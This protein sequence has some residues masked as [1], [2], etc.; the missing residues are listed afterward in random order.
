MAPLAAFLQEI[1]VKL[2]ANQRNKYSIVSALTFTAYDI[3]I[4]SGQEIK[5]IWRSKRSLVTVL[6]FVVRYMSLVNLILIVTVRSLTGLS[7][8]VCQRYYIWVMLGSC[9]VIVIA[10]NAIMLLRVFA[11]YK[12]C[13]R[14]FITL[15][16]LVLCN[17]AAV[18]WGHITVAKDL[19]A[20]VFAVP[21][22]WEGCATRIPNIRFGLVA[23]IPDFMLSL[24]F[25]VMTLRKLVESHE[26]YHGKLSWRSL[27]PDDMENASPLV[28]AFVRDGTIFFALSTA[29]TFLKTM[30]VSIVDEMDEPGFYPWLFALDSYIGAHLILDLRAAV[31]RRKGKSTWN[32]ALS[33]Q[34]H[35]PMFAED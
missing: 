2:G 22:P 24:V 26:G 12:R 4:S 30:A 9:P 33:M 1:I 35:D 34:Y 21:A 23:Y 7:V 28:V 20:G 32:E 8:A 6:Y 10:L 25:L 13:K 3:V 5:Y 15:L 18:L 17:A 19:A 29:V 16:V 31:T 14:V 11:I 27:K